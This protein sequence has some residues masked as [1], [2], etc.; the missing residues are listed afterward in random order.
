MNCITAQAVPNSPK[1]RA[2][3]AVSLSTKLSTSFGRIG[4]IRPSANM[5]SRMV[6]K[7]KA[8]APVRT[9]GISA[10]A[11]G[12]RLAHDGR[13]RLWANGL[14]FSRSVIRTGVPGRSKR[15]T[16]A[17]GEIAQIGRRHRVGTRAEQDETRRA[18]LGLRDVVQL[19]PAA[20]HRRRRIGVDRLLEPAIERRRR[21]ALVPDRIGLHDRGHQPVDAL[22]H[23]ARHRDDRRALDLR[24]PMIGVG[25]QRRNQAA[26]LLHQ[27]PFVDGQHDRPPLALDQVGDAQI[28]FL[29][30]VLRVHHHHDD[31]GKTH[32]AQRI[33]H[34]QLFQ[35]LVDPGAPP[36]SGGIEHPEVAPLPRQPRP[37]WNRAWCRPRRWS[38][39]APRRADD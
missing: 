37:K 21:H 30:P 36:Q 3:V 16:Q 35:L 18:R 22:A 7:M 14:A 17:V 31:F 23:Q 32:R 28:L 10:S 15:L 2:A 13:L 34:R 20:R 12:R 19:Q 38:T 24:Q 29:E 4:R 33:R 6:T 11:R 8:A 27:I 26:F 25:A 1:I 5:S 9:G 39:T